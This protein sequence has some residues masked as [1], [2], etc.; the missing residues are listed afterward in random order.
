M[1]PEFIADNKD[2]DAKLEKAVAGMERDIPQMSSSSVSMVKNAMC[3]DFHAHS[4]VCAVA[5]R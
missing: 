1:T 4:R 5:K 2:I 3:R